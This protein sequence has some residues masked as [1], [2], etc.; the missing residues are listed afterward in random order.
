[1]NKFI[2]P[3]LLLLSLSL[4]GCDF[5][6]QLDTEYV[7]D[8]HYTFHNKDLVLRDIPMYHDFTIMK[9]SMC[10]GTP[11]FR[12]GEF[13]MQG[14]DL[15]E[16]VYAFYKLQ[17]PRKGWREISTQNLGSAAYLR[18]GNGKEL[19]TISIRENPEETELRM[20]VEQDNT[21]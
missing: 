9:G 5:A 15:V 6:Q 21:L 19:V 18:F 16:E 12:Y 14:E 11:T 2:L 17:L 8:N 4:T 3:I 10:Y 13:L 7:R 20:I 1:M